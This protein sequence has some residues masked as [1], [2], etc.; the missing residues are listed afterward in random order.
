MI[1][2]FVVFLAAPA[3]AVDESVNSSLSTNASLEIGAGITPDSSFYFVES[4]ILSRFRSDLR[5][6][7]KKIAEI[8]AM[9]QKGDVQS[10]KIALNKYKGYA[11]EA[12]N[13]VDPEKSSEAKRSSVAIENTIKKIEEK[14]PAENKK[15]FVD[16]INQQER[17]IST[18]AEL[19]HKIKDLCESLSKVD[20][21]E[22]TRACRTSGE[23][24]T[25]QKNLDKKLTK[26]QEQE[27]EAFFKVMSQC[28]KTPEQCD[29]GSITVASFAAVCKEKAPLAAQ[30]QKGDQEAC[31]KM[32]EGTDPRTLL[33]EHLQHVFDRLEGDYTNAKFEHYLPPECKEAN[34]TSPKECEKIMFR[35]HAPEE[36]R[37]AVDAG[38][39][40]IDTFK[41]FEKKCQEIMFRTHAPKECVDAGLTD[42]KECGQLIFKLK[43][44]KECTDNGLTGSERGDEQRCREIMQQKGNEQQGQGPGSFSASRCKELQ[45]KE[46]KLKCFEEAFSNAQEHYG[47]EGNGAFNN[48]SFNNGKFEDRNGHEG[49]QRNFPG[50]CVQANALTSEECRKVMDKSSQEQ[51]KQAQEE[52]RQNEEK[53]KQEQSQFECAPGTVKKCDNERCTCIP[54]E[55]HTQPPTS[56]TPPSHGPEP[57]PSSQPATTSP[58]T[59]KVIGVD[60]PFVNYYFR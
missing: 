11:H 42:P 6:R 55:Q 12:E 13:N 51:Q 1:F 31:K 7:E 59:G 56:T 29:C 32:N 16:D 10:A 8:E 58:M 36:C 24:P 3:M 43:A 53:H 47:S 18:A 15:E 37:K 28:F 22:Y 34:V 39:L 60:N 2:V 4:G 17:K 20:P 30:C 35:E 44:P 9:I 21:Q 49:G 5:N 48:G 14:I 33:P 41:E 54:A 46:E 52:R 27:A 25:W 26:E 57:P 50:P 45:D 40:S 19:S 23:S 38:E